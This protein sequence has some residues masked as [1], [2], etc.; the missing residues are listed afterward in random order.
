M[1][2]L[3]MNGSPNVNGNTARALEEMRKIFEEEGI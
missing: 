1:K 2:V 3:L